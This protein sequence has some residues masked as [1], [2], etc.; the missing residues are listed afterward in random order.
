MIE[1]RNDMRSIYDINTIRG[2]KM[3]RERLKDLKNT[4]ICKFFLLSEVLKLFKMQ[5]IMSFFSKLRNVGT[6]NNQIILAICAIQLLACG[7]WFLQV[8]LVV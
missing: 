7:A 6:N 2:Y 8:N 1:S 5:E 3:I 4:V